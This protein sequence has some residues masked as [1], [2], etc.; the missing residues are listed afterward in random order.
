[1]T[2][3]KTWHEIR[4]QRSH[5]EQRVEVY[6]L[7]MDAET[8]LHELRERRGV[9]QAQLAAALETSQPNVSRIEREDDVYLSTLSRYVV[10]L[11]GRIEV[12]AVFPDETVTVVTGPTSIEPAG[13]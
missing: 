6:K 3:T 13:V 11:G 4:A 7:L 5:D 10:A 1:M 12:N 2:R 9:S 8:M